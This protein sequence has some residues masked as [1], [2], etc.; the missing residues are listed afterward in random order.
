MDLKDKIEE[1]YKVSIKENDSNSVNTLRLIKSAI[2]DKEISA[3]S[4]NVN[5]SDNDILALL[6]NLIKQRKDSITA[7]AQANRDD[8]INKEKEEIKIIEILLPKQKNE[9]ET[10][11]I[12]ITL[13]K[14]N[15]FSSIKDM[16][17]LMN[18]LK[19][20]FAGQVDIG[21]ASKIAKIKLGS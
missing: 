4:K 9:E 11:E 17:K 5:I 14:E 2:K 7:F 18:L 15:N 10:N 1:M 6:Q 13:I 20:D 8:L 12:I 19:T 3:R 21:V 16:G